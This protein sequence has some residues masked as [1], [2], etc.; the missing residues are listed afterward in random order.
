[1][2]DTN[3]SMPSVPNGRRFLSKEVNV[4]RIILTILGIVG[5][6]LATPL[7]AAQWYRFGQEIETGKEERKVLGNRCTKVESSIDHQNMLLMEQRALTEE[8]RREQSSMIR[9]LIRI[10]TKLENNNGSD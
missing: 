6:A 2:T 10:E 7:I 1:V 5:G 4:K 9:S 3:P 8:M